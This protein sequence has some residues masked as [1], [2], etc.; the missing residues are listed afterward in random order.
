MP[1]QWGMDELFSARTI[2]LAAL[3]NHLNGVERCNKVQRF[4][5]NRIE[6]PDKETIE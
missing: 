5:E 6:V 4:E 3:S 2:H 1:I